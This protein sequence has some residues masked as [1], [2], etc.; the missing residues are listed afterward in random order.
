MTW[1]FERLADL[2][3]DA[4]REAR[5]GMASAEAA[6]RDVKCM[7]GVVFFYCMEGEKLARKSRQTPA[8]VQKRMH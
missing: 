4:E 8:K 6:T 2:R 3:E 5:M 1:R 7:M